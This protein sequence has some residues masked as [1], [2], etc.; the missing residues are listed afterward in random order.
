[1]LRRPFQLSA[2]AWLA[3][4]ILGSAQ[5]FAAAT[6][7]LELTVE[8]GKHDREHT[9]VSVPIQLPIAF[10]DATVASLSGAGAPAMAQITAPNLLAKAPAVEGS[11]ARELNFV[12]PS[13]KAGKSLQLTAT[14]STEISA[15]PSTAFRWVDT[16]GEYN[17]LQAGDKPVLRYMYKK[18][19]DSS[20]EAR[21]QTY[22][23]FHHVYNP[24]GSAIITKG[25]GGKYTHH[26]GLYFGFNRVSYGDGKKADVW[27]CSGDAHQSHE[28]VASE[29][30]GPV[31]GRHRLKID[32]HGDKKEVFASEER[33]LT[34]YKLPGGTLIQ[35]SSRVTPVIEPVRLDGDPQ[36]AG[37]HFRASGEVADSTSKQTYYLRTDGKGAMGETRN[38][39]AGK[40][41]PVNLP[42]N[43]MSFVTGGSRY[44]VA[45][46]DRPENPKEARFSERDYGRFGSYFEY[47]LKQDKPL[48]ISYR[49]W[50]QDGE[51]TGEAVA[52]LATDFTDPVK[53]TVA[54]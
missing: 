5:A 12:L 30:T 28:G 7:T 10:K 1:M 41:G 36:H 43:A 51:T 45:N 42:W 8:A 3:A 2:I 39:A 50:V 33:E 31:L 24:A 13:L 40:G 4:C 53:V 6:T 49:I 21:E 19:D 46:L 48:E 25:P 23:P 54:K 27:H 17:E 9:P 32:W 35:F 14:V 22:K 38:W 37:F 16:P 18:L 52:A 26:R 47:D 29:D 11:V 34:A 44:T 15:R 20:K